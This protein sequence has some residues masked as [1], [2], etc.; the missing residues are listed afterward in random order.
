MKACHAC[1]GAALASQLQQTSLTVPGLVNDFHYS[2]ASHLGINTYY[3]YSW[4][5][6]KNQA[7]LDSSQPIGS[8]SL[9]SP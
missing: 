1:T 8:L 3:F 6:A 7:T 9:T 5:A 2:A 4:D